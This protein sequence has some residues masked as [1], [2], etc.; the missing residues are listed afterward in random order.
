MEVT[1]PKSGA[2]EV[3]PAVKGAGGG[4]LATALAPSVLLPLR[5]VVTGV[6][7]LVLAAGILIARP[8]LLSTYHYNQ[9]IIAVTH[10]VVLGFVTSIIMGAM[11]QLVPV[12]LETSLFSERLARWQFLAH[13][14]GLAG[15]VWMFWRWD[16]KQVGH[17]GSVF[18]VGVGLF[19]Y[20]IG[21]TLLRVRRWNAVAGGIGVD[22]YAL[23][24]ARGVRD[25][26]QR[27]QHQ[28]PDDVAPADGA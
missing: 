10:L 24:R 23:R 25:L 6:T 3:K 2:R 20:N 12:A 8:D 15:M 14:V 9:H 22:P 21:R 28:Q 27:Q 1:S 11:Y 18:A 4:V 26:Q 19:V 7:A 5:F 13:I 17:F 16:M